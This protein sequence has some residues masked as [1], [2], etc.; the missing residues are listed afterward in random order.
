[1]KQKGQAMIE[2]SFVMP[3]LMFFLL[4][5]IY[6]GMLFVDYIHFN[7]AVR[8][9]ARDIALSQTTGKREEKM[10]NI[11]WKN[12]VEPIT[13]LYPEDSIAMTAKYVTGDDEVDNEE[14]ADAV[15]VTITLTRV[16][17]GEPFDSFIILPENMAISYRMKLE[18]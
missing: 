13:N 18:N 7:N 17:F 15:R 12:Y 4:A 16:K 10:K 3:V 14:Q 1:M 2:F 8:Y 6:V 5:I 9:A 11:D